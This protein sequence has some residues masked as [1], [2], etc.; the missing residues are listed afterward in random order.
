ML[1]TTCYT[2][3]CIYY[4]HNP[5]TVYYILHAIHYTAFKT[6][7]NKTHNKLCK[8]NKARNIWIQNC[9]L[10]STHYIAYAM[11]SFQSPR[12]AMP[13]Y[14]DRCFYSMYVY[15]WLVVLCICIVIVSIVVHVLYLV[16][17]ILLYILL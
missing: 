7:S 1:Y 14:M 2:V 6:W 3:Y 13:F 5:Y 11:T 8:H 9:R 10:H 15:I 17:N 12:H 4:M 16:P